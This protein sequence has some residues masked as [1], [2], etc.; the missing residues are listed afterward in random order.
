MNVLHFLLSTVDTT[1]VPHPEVIPP[2]FLTTT[3]VVPFSS[4]L[5][6][7][8]P[9]VQAVNSQ[10]IIGTKDQTL[11]RASN[12]FQ[13][14]AIRAEKVVE[15]TASYWETAIE[16]RRSNWPLVA[17]PLRDLSNMVGHRGGFVG[18]AYAKDFRVAYS[19]ESGTPFLQRAS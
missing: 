15:Q 9:S 13:E 4:S 3:D 17:A 16:L 5:P 6:A 18:E 1:Y 19:L 12:I 2:G 10:I 11:R 8:L 14:A 7:G